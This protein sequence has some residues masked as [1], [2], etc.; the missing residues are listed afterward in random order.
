M[1]KILSTGSKGEKDN[2]IVE[3]K[4]IKDLI[5]VGQDLENAIIGVVK[6]NIDPIKGETLEVEKVV[7][8]TLL[9]DM[10]KNIIIEEDHLMKK[11]RDILLLKVIMKRTNKKRFNKVKKLKVI[12]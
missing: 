7:T 5:G 6:K 1:K 10:T 8:D 3:M 9:N 11:E 4:S 2:R 12:I